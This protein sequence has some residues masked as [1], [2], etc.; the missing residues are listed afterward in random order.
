VLGAV[1]PIKIKK[2]LSGN[3]IASLL[4]FVSALIVTILLARGQPKRTG[5]EGALSITLILSTILFASSFLYLI[6]ANAKFM[7]NTATINFIGRHIYAARVALII[8][9][10]LIYALIL[11]SPK[12]APHKTGPHGFA[13]SLRS[14][15]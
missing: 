11:F 8:I 15:N 5:H 7:E 4:L 1:V 6:A 3:L 10:I 2:F 12:K 9:T 13:L 14:S